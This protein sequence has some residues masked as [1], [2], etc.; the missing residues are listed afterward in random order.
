MRNE[1]CCLARSP[2]DTSFRDC[3]QDRGRLFS[4]DNAAGILQRLYCLLSWECETSESLQSGR[5]L[6]C[7][8]V[9]RLAFSRLK[10][11]VCFT[12]CHFYRFFFGVSY[13]SWISDVI[14]TGIVTPDRIW[15]PCPPFFFWPECGVAYYFL[16]ISNSDLKSITW[17]LGVTFLMLM[18]C[19]GGTG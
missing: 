10:I 15:N 8:L 2:S 19:V 16:I 13:T 5:C 11:T 3:F 14:V 17:I 7:C 1:A 6:L 12:R 18:F 4:G 9:A